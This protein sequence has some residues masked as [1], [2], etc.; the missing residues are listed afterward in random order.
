MIGGWDGI[1]EFVAVARA[2]SFTA[3]ARAFG[4]SVTH[5]SRAV[6]RLE[7]RLETQLFNR[8]TRSLFLTDTGRIFLEQ[9]QRLVDEREEAIA[10]I[11]SQGQPR[12][13]LRLTCSYALGERFVSPL[14]RE[15][16][17]EHPSLVVTLDLDNDVVD[18]VSRGYD[19]AVR[20][21][22]LEDSRLIATRVAQRELV[23]VASRHYLS[24]H[25]EPREIAELTAHDC[26]VG[27]S[28][29][30][31]FRRGQ[32]F[33]PRG[34][35]HCNSGTTVVDACLAGMGICQLPAFY[36]REHLAAGRL[37]EVLEDER[38]E[39]EPIWAIYPTRRH[40]SPKV[41]GLVAL[42]RAKLQDRLEAAKFQYA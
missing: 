5:M 39:D 34:R 16:A 9:C 20:T 42:L 27:S 11:A 23:T 29:Q 26:L 17:Q 37:Q 35:W 21:G 31:H 24:S 1:E 8:T 10:G 4:A 38:P 32:S 13:A 3:G 25:G 15:F 18:I 33:R 2:G 41:S 40:L 28:S 7:A 36:V 22:H 14:V 19:L 12:G 6:A 30:W